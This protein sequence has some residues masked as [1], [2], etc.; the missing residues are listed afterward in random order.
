MPD[1][2]KCLTCDESKFREIKNDECICKKN[3]EE[4]EKKLCKK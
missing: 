2:D 3:Y 4:N 1:L